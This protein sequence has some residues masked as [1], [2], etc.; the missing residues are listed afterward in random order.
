M[1]QPDDAGHGPDAHPFGREII[2]DLT[3]LTA[4]DGACAVAAPR[5]QKE[6]TLLGGGLKRDCH[7]RVGDPPYG[8]FIYAQRGGELRPG[9]L[10][11]VVQVV[12][13]G[14]G[15]G[16][17][18]PSCVAAPRC[19]QLLRFFSGQLRYARGLAPT[20][21]T[22]YPPVPL[23]GAAP[24][25]PE[26]QA[27][28][29]PGESFGLPCGDE[30]FVVEELGAASGGPSPDVV[31][32]ERAPDRCF[33][34]ADVSGDLSACG[35]ALIRGHDALF[36]HGPSPYGVVFAPMEPQTRCPR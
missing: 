8:A 30:G 35:V 5:E 13:Q 28:G 7:D 15:G 2:Q 19:A 14:V 29:L 24:A 1:V 27:Q 22:K 12:Q 31:P 6:S 26:T 17:A 21:L 36:V 32:V 20:L 34:T 11:V 4:W 3:D 33:V 23:A 25:Q 10:S 16:G 18:E 9:Q